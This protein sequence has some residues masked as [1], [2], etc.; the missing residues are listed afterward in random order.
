MTS[1][2]QVQRLTALDRCDRCGAQAYVQVDL[3]Q[4]EL[5]FCS[6][7]A[8]QY[9]DKLRQLAILIRDEAPALSR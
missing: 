2:A 9:D 3:A 5:L 1:T 7:H 6:H 4:G 8:R